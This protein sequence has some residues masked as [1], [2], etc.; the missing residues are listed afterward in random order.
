MSIERTLQV[1]NDGKIASLA[2]EHIA[3]LISEMKQRKIAQLT[4]DYRSGADSSR[5]MAGAAA[6]AVLEEL[7][8]EIKARISRGERAANDLNKGAHT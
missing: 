4:Q 8:N 2:A 3:S 7:E 5:Y 6:I 1:I